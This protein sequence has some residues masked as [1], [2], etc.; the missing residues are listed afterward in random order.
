MH[1]PALTKY[2]GIGGGGT[3]VPYYSRQ[4]AAGNFIPYGGMGDYL[5]LPVTQG[6]SGYGTNGGGG[7]GWGTIFSA[8]AVGFLMGVLGG[9]AGERAIFRQ[10]IREAQLPKI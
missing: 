9:T 7:C 6:M 1:D 5:F 2:N 3:T 8:V 4:D 10:K